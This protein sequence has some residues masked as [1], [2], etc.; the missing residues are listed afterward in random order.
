MR[1]GLGLHEKLKTLAVCDTKTL[2]HFSTNTYA[3][4]GLSFITILFIFFFFSFY[5]IFISFSF[6]KYLV[7]EFIKT[8]FVN[9]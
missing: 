6:L 5:H 8:P 9:S 2:I 1:E 3:V 7:G 4:I